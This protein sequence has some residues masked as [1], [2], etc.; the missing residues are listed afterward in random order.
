MATV[1]NK[2]YICSR[3]LEVAFYEVPSY[4]AP[5]PVGV[6]PIFGSTATGGLGQHSVGPAFKYGAQKP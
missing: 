6:V 5:F 1:K 2:K 4:M 3:R